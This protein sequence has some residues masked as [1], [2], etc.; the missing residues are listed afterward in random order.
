MVLVDL[1]KKGQKNMRLFDRPIKK[2]TV[3]DLQKLCYDW[4]AFCQD[5]MKYK[6]TVVEDMII[7]YLNR[8]E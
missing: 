1:N 7:Q 2:M 6:G 4:K 3:K 5:P 8:D